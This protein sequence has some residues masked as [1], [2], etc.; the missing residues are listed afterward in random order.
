VHGALNNDYIGV[1][2]GVSVVSEPNIPTEDVLGNAE[3]FVYPVFPTCAV[4]GGEK[5]YS[6]TCH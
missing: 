6:E 2:V 3:W 4:I 5:S 1:G